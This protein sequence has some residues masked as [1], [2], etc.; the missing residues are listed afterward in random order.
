MHWMCSN[1]GHDD[2]AVGVRVI[3]R[4][5]DAAHI[6]SCIHE[7]NASNCGNRDEYILARGWCEHQANECFGRCAT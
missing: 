6:S 3:G 7:H 2:T 4:I 1:V 5:W